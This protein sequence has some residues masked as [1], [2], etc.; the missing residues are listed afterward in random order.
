MLLPAILLHL[1]VLVECLPMRGSEQETAAGLLEY[2]ILE[3]L[4]SKR[5][6]K[7]TSRVGATTVT[8]SI[9]NWIEDV[10]TV[11][12]FLNV[13]LNLP[14][15][16]VLKAGASKALYFAQDEPINNKFLGNMKGLDSAGIAAAATL[17]RTFGDVLVQ[18]GNVVDRP[19]SL[20][21]A[22]NAV[23]RINANR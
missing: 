5:A 12:S 1:L 7:T 13:A 19:A 17:D 21:V 4:I 11:N 3:E 15:G 14:P 9:N 18:L 22:I 6:S 8:Q 2:R 20:P 23:A 10:D 16:P